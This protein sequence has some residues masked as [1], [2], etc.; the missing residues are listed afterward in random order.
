MT[1]GYVFAGCES[2]SPISMYFGTPVYLIVDNT[3]AIADSLLSITGWLTSSDTAVG[4]AE[5]VSLSPLYTE[6]LTIKWLA[7]KEQ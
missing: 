2:S 7:T 3:F 5:V 1:V 4:I 6:S